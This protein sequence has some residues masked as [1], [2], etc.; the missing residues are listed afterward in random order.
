MHLNLGTDR[1]RTPRLAELDGWRAVSVLLVIL[2]HIG[3]YQHN[4][5]VSR[6]SFLDLRVRYLGP[7]GV[8]IFFVI[9]GFVICRLLILEESRY[10]SVSLKGFYYRRIFRILPP[11]Y[12]YLAALSLLLC[13]GLIHESWRAI[14]GSALFLFNINVVPH[15][16]FVG[17]TWSLALEEQ[18]Y[19][20]F[21]T[22]WVLMPKACK[23][24]IFLGL[25][26]LLAA[27]NLSMIYTGW[28][29][30]IST[31]SR[32]GFACIC[33]GVLIAIYE[34]RA[35]AVANAVPA[36]LVVLVL[37]MLL[38]HP[39]GAK[40]GKAALYESLIVPPAIGL[41]LL[42]SLQRG[43]WLRAFLCSK[44]VQGIGLTS[45]GIYLWQQLFTAPKTYFSSTGQII[46]M[47]LPLLCLIVPLSYFILEKP[48]MRYGKSFSQRT[49]EPPIDGV[50]ES[51]ATA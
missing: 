32:A 11:F 14:L 24:Q 29:A 23:G 33:F 19:L 43:V 45:Y 13:L 36:F 46:S 18:F 31:S 42:F 41:G 44:P 6:S 49:N 35:R 25:F 4:A 39:V 22:M 7:L 15:S 20:V 17:H 34:T 37:L 5:V 26:F 27:W 48:A 2:H 8:K 10:G 3:G 50:L 12:I 40:T 38:Y 47:L 9:S 21:P 28:D 30:L 1:P 51:E 16:W